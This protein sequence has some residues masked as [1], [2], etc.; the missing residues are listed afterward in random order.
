MNAICEIIHQ[1]SPDYLTLELISGSRAEHE[2]K[3]R[4]QLEALH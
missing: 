3:I 4:T 1:I 2:H